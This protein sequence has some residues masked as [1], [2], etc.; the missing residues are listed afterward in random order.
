M[1]HRP[2]ALLLDLHYGSLQ[3]A[4]SLVRKG[5]R[6]Y[7]LDTSS[8]SPGSYSRY[9]KQLHP[10]TTKENLGDFLVEFGK[11]VGTPPVLYP[12]S[13]FYL[14]FIQ[15]HRDVL[16]DH[17]LFPKRSLDTVAQL[18]SKVETARLFSRMKIDSPK[19]IH[20]RKGTSACAFDGFTYPCILKPDY[21]DNWEND[22]HASSYV[23]WGNR[24]MVIENREIL[25]NAIERLSPIDD[26]ICQEII[27]GESGSYYY[28]VGYRDRKGK[29]VASF[30][31]NKLR[32][33]PDCT[34]SET[35]LISVDRPEL[36]RR[37]DD[38]LHQLGY[39]GPAGIDFKYDSRNGELKV[40]EIN[41]RFGINDGY[42]MKYGIDLPYFYYL[43]SQNIEVPSCR[44]YPSAVTWY[45]LLADFYW[46]REYRKK[47]GIT[48]RTWIGQLFTY[49]TYA[50]FD[51]LDPAP[52]VQ[53]AC[54]ILMRMCRKHLS[55]GMPLFGKFKKRYENL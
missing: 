45:D 12:L 23:G 21:H 31:G 18:I 51:W 34:G 4:K 36:I 46:M 17:F 19:S 24:V 30:A 48:W 16:C 49:D 5:I 29:I 38:I 3:V 14:R 26:M 40:I 33:L 28:Y 7:G 55:I 15:T 27:P 43:D 35:V 53:S 22:R 6:V 2:P 13:D 9:I 41:C 39:H 52:F 32:T 8:G 44:T 42:M 25:Q 50:L 10:P 1:A 47:Y 37:G 20:I 11:K 54:K